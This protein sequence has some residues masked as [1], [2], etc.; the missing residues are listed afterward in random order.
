[1]NGL[2]GKLIVKQGKGSKGIELH[3]ASGLDVY[4]M[5]AINELLRSRIRK[6]KGKQ[7]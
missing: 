4:R 6:Q 5:L 2:A 7:L 1:V 3:E